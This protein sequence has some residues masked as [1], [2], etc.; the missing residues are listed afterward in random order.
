MLDEVTV[1]L[2]LLVKS[3]TGLSQTGSETQGKNIHFRL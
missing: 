1:P 2:L 3:G